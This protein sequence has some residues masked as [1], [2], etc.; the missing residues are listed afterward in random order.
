MVKFEI[1]SFMVN[2]FYFETEIGYETK[3][4]GATE[5]LVTVLGGDHGRVWSLLEAL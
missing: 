3:T 5:L 1:F 4:K 2:F